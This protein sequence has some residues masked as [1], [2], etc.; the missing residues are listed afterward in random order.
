MKFTFRQL[1]LAA[2]FLLLSACGGDEVAIPTFDP[3]TDFP[4][5]E[6]T[7]TSTC[8]DGDNIT[9]GTTIRFE[10]GD[11]TVIDG[12]EPIN[13]ASIGVWNFTLTN[14]AAGGLM[15]EEVRGPMG[16][17]VSF[18]ARAQRLGPAAICVVVTDFSVG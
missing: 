17:P 12:E 1:I 8:G 4:A 10:N 9:D 6:L 14:A 2:S 16:E 11:V 7:Y 5:Y 15:I 13:V 18:T 3:F